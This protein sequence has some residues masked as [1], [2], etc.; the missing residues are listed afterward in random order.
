MK[1]EDIAVFDRVE[2]FSLL[3]SLANQ[4]LSVTNLIKHI[5]A[6]MQ[7]ADSC[8]IICNK[9]TEV[10]HFYDALSVLENIRV[11]YLT[12]NLCPKHR[13]DIIESLD[14]LLTNNRQGNINKLICI[15]TQLIEAGV[16]LDFDLVYRE[17]A[18]LDSLIQSAGRCNREG[19]R[20]V[21][22]QPTRDRKSV[23]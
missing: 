16:D 7:V 2:Y 19:K 23:V 8:L 22:N 21:N 18:G 14:E 15:S 12:T 17:A 9:K 1:S 20:M 11:V 5:L 13:L 3:G 6:E 4:R 10:K